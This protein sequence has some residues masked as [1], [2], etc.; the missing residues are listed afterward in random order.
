MS[1]PPLFSSRPASA[2]ALL[3]IGGP[4][5]FGAICGW[6]L[7]VSEAAYVLLAGPVA[8][9]GGVG[10][11]L[12]HHGGRSGALRGVLGGLLFGAS[13]LVLHEVSG[14]D[15]K[16]SLPDPP[17]L[18]LALT[19]AGGTLLGGLGGRLRARR[20]PEPQP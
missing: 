20:A 4:V 14:K 5:A 16:A 8:I 19:A 6:L 17:V 13:I 9:L 7:G 12:E 1:L 2:R 10:A 11:G 15:P 3:A 18:L